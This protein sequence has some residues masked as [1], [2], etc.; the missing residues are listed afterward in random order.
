MKDIFDESIVKGLK[1]RIELLGVGST[2]KWG[3]FNVN[4]MLCH[5]QD[6]LRYA[7]GI[8]KEEKELIKGP[9]VFLRSIIRLYIPWPKNSPT[10]PSMLQTKPDEIEKDKLLLFELLEQ[11]R[12]K[13]EQQEWPFHP[14]FGK[15]DGIGW[16]RLIYRHMDYHLKQFGL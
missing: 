4:K 7:T 1:E 5:L 6:N 12:E 13:K 2:P 8:F 9:P 3:K 10:A 15:L 16:A 11:V 14:F